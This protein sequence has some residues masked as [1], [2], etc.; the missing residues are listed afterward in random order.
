MTSIFACKAQTPIVSLNTPRYQ[1]DVGAYFKDINNE[2]NQ[3]IGSW[4]YTNESTTFEITIEKK[5]MVYNG[6]Y[7]E[8]LLIGE[9]KYMVNGVIEIN[10]LPRL[11]M[12]LVE[13]RKHSISGRQILASDYYN[14]PCDDCLL[15]E[16]RVKLHLSDP[17]RLYLSTSSITLRYLLNESPEKLSI[18]IKGESGGIIPENVPDQGRFPLGDFILI[19]Q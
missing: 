10:T 19:K 3:F 4:K 12:S 11:T 18:L 15:S 7:Y 8:D 14:P 13:G 2:L 16:K 5:E 6:K 9:Y 17:D 1:T